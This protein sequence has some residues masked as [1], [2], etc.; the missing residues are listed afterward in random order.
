MTMSSSLITCSNK[1]CYNQDY[2]KLDL[3]SN[4]VYCLKCNK[5]ISVNLYLKKI[6]KTNNQV[7]RKVDV[8]VK[9]QCPHCKV[10]DVPI[11]LEHGKGVVDVA[12]QH[13]G[14]INDHLT[15]YFAEP[16]RMNESVPRIK[17]KIARRDSVDVVVQADGSPLP[18]HEPNK[19]KSNVKPS[20]TA[21]KVSSGQSADVALK[22]T[23][24][25][26]DSKSLAEPQSSVRQEPVTAEAMLKRAGVKR[27][28]ED[29]P[30]EAPA[31]RP[32]NIKTSASAEKTSKKARK[33]GPLTAAEMLS[34]SG[35]RNLARHDDGDGG[36][37]SEEADG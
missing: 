13:C 8:G 22:V 4:E 6:L 36:K 26:V 10:N 3:D 30:S 12:C 18:W 16:L 37:E 11:L 34:R 21:T 20:A 19:V 9:Y 7:F 27:L 17:V 33:P 24:E 23:P 5:P 1:G 35:I 15:T 29:V 2:H 28:T 32:V 14:R 25:S 31:K